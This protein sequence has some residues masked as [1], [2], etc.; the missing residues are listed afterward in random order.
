MLL[1]HD[2]PIREYAYGPA[3]G[4]PETKVGSFPPVL[5][6][7]TKSNSWDVISMK[8]DWRRIFAFDK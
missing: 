8:V 1:L 4:L 2:D 7:E 6:D 5:D 3:R